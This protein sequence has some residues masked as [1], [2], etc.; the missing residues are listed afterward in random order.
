M[1][2]ILGIS[3]RSNPTLVGHINSAGAEPE[4]GS[5]SREKRIKLRGAEVGAIK[6]VKMR[7]R[8]DAGLVERVSAITISMT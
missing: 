8:Q 3:R 2:R 4:T 7:A 1:S 6:Q 5:D